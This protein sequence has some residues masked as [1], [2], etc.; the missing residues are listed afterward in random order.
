MPN[1]LLF[2]GLILRDF[3]E[4]L[5]RHLSSRDA[6]EQLL[7]RYGWSI[8][9]G[10]ALF[11]A[12]DERSNVRTP[13]EEFLQKAKVLQQSLDE[14]GDFPTDEQLIDLAD[15]AQRA[16]RAIA[17][18]E[19]SSFA[20]LPEPLNQA[21]FWLDVGAHLVDDLL[22]E[23]V[24]VYYPGGY[25][26]LHLLGIIR[27]DI[28]LP[29]EPKRRA[30]ARTLV[31]WNQAV[32]VVVDPQ[33]A[34]QKVYRWDDPLH[35][36]DHERLFA[37][38]ES[39]LRAIHISAR[40]AAPDRE[41]VASVPLEA[42]FGVKGDAAG[43]LVRLLHAIAPS[44]G[45]VF[46]CGIEVLVAQRDTDRDASGLLIRPVVRGAAETVIA[47]RP[48]LDLT[49]SSTAE[50]GNVLAAVVFPEK[51]EWIGGGADSRTSIG[52]S[53]RAGSP[54]FLIGN[55][56]TAHIE[57][58]DF[59]GGLSIGEGGGRPSVTLYVRCGRDGAPG[60]R[61]VI[62]LDEADTFVR[63]VSGRN[64]LEFSF[65]AE[66][67][68]TDRAGLRFNGG[69]LV[70]RTLPVGIPI[71][72]VVLH[73]VRLA[74]GT[75]DGP[76]SRPELYFR[77]GVGLEAH[78][79]PFRC[80]IS[81]VGFTLSAISYTKA[82][83]EALP[84]DDRPL[85]GT[86]DLRLGFA[87]PTAV[88]LVI[89]TGPIT[90]AGYLEFEGSRYTGMLQL[91]LEQIG[92]KAF[93]IIETRL[94]GGQEGYSFLILLSAEFEPG[95]E[96]GFGFVLKAVGGLIG[97]NRT[98]DVDVLQALV[99]QRSLDHILFPKDVETDAPAIISGLGS[100]FPPADG[101][102]IFGP[103]ARI[104]WGKGKLE[105]FEAELAVILEV[106]NEPVRLAILGQAS[107][108]L[109]RKETPVVLLH[110]D[111]V[112]VLEFSKKLFAL[113]A[114]V[115][116][117][118]IGG[119]PVS[120]DMALRLNWGEQPNFALAVGG[121]HPDFQAPPE[122]PSLRRMVMDLGLNG[123]PRLTLT[124]YLAITSNTVQI[125]AAIDLEA[126]FGATVRGHLGFNALFNFSPFSF[127][128]DISGGVELYALRTSWG[129]HLHGTLEGPSPWRA[130]GR[131]CVDLWL[132]DICVRFEATFGGGEPEQLTALGD[133]WTELKLALEEPRNWHASLPTGAASVVSFSP[134]GQGGPEG[135]PLLDPLGA[136]TVRQ[137]VVPLNRPITRFGP[138][139]LL[140]PTIFKVIGGSLGGVPVTQTFV[141]DFF[142]PAQFIEMT[143]DEK[144]S[145]R[146][147][148]SWDSGF[149]MEVA[150]G[151]ASGPDVS[152]PVTFDTIIIDGDQEL[153][154]IPFGL[155]ARHLDGMLARSAGAV[156][157]LRAIGAEK[158][159]DLGVLPQVSLQEET[160]R[161]AT[162]A[163][164]SLLTDAAMTRSEALLALNVHVAAHPEDFGR[165]QV[166]PAFEVAGVNHGDE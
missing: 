75:A 12:I 143:N 164:L 146:S 8:V 81:R 55:A 154:P 131:A 41:T 128:G 24:R 155:L 28:I 7:F 62:P 56:R 78:L 115:H 34:F 106:G 109:P 45:T 97:I 80:T 53:H 29:T 76:A 58:L 138:G 120:G 25:L 112:G 20:S 108:V 126:K 89:E 33:R 32:E 43:L 70:D 163:D 64:G 110:L 4:P 48:S 104:V 98:V 144:L 124:G 152:S 122:F 160:Y 90:G 158:Y 44:D 116:D 1:Q 26:V 59:S 102:Y 79:G 18:F 88:G 22:E 127:T 38:L 85:F 101:R 6:L 61:V 47:I 123:N 35:R 17:G 86:I 40:V 135:G 150:G 114:K 60:F 39:A 2:L 73:D 42:A 162:I 46:E 103:M 121:F 9:L 130:K 117:S 140:E 66:I 141:K 14:T 105:L 137:S 69:G 74:L 84:A 96:L 94:A 107:F 36:F 82:E 133:P 159:I 111:V 72:P 68:W 31:D 13:V 91:R 166:V 5:Q 151:L 142:A 157:G 65:A 63:D 139:Q 165:L 52:L 145:S 21:E 148:E 83:L 100:V 125:G 149:T 16:L 113:D 54:R 10:D 119:F 118:V 134:R 27:Y 3:L 57:V 19:L 92:V 37:A 147:F 71:G 95:I 49:W 30:Y 11:E 156:G 132:K 93:G 161:I 129:V 153:P 136:A 87:P 15:S 77:V 99:R 51:L 50:R 67:T 23:Y